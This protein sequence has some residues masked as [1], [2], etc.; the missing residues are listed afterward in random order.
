MQKIRSNRKKSAPSQH[1]LLK[2]GE[3][4]YKVPSIHPTRPAK[5]LFPALQ[6]RF[7]WQSS[8]LGWTTIPKKPEAALKKPRYP[9]PSG[10]HAHKILR[11]PS[12]EKTYRNLRANPEPPNPNACW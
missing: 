1:A 11:P 2:F 8:F 9:P 5:E 3:A 12:S 4:T 6:K 10:G 7:F